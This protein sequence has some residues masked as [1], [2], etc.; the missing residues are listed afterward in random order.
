MKRNIGKDITFKKNTFNEVC[1]RYSDSN[2]RVHLHSRLSEQESNKKSKPLNNIHGER[3]S[4][5]GPEYTDGHLHSYKK[6]SAKCF[7]ILA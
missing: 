2:S 3:V 6:F 4:L 1:R 5:G 7:T